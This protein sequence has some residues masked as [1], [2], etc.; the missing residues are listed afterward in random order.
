[1]G[2]PN[3]GPQVLDQSTCKNRSALRE[4][5]TSSY[6]IRHQKIF[7]SRGG[8]LNDVDVDQFW[9]TCGPCVSMPRTSLHRILTSSL[10]RPI[11]YNRSVVSIEEHVA[12]ADVTFDDNASE[13]YDLVIGS[14]G[15]RSAVRKALSPDSQPEYLG[16]VCWRFLADNH[17]GLNCWTAM[18]GAR[19]TAL[20]I[21]IGPEKIY[22]YADLAAGAA[23]HDETTPLSSLKSL[24]GGFAEPFGTIM[25][26][27]RSSDPIHV[28]R[29]EENASLTSSSK[30]IVLIG[31]AAHAC[32]PSMAQGAGMG[33]EDAIVLA[34]LLETS[35][36]VES[37]LEKF[38][39]RREPRTAWVRRQCHARDRLRVLPPVARNLILRTLGTKLYARSYGSLLKSI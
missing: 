30:S 39:H 38:H 22:V 37:A 31:D 20:A 13:R 12:G 10:M 3:G 18:I 29:L 16:N 19:R 7:D 5:L 1:M 17:V 35:A 24:F 25:N 8:L 4:V 36:S 33:L 9:S 28:G 27:L 21:P 23:Y 34:E 11:T 2:P 14:D 6:P 15:I 26:D 32:S